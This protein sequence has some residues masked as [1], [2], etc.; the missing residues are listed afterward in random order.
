[1]LVGEQK[2]KNPFGKIFINKEEDIF[3]LGGKSNL[4]ML[5]SKRGEE[6]EERKT[7]RVMDP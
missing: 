6:E 1:M 2:G 5:N 3:D 4:M 7:M